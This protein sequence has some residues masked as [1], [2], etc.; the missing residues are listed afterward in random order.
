MIAPKNLKEHAAAYVNTAWPIMMIFFIIAAYFNASWSAILIGYAGWPLFLAGFLGLLV[1]WINNQ[2][3]ASDSAAVS[4]TLAQENNYAQIKETWEYMKSNRLFRKNVS[5]WTLGWSSVFIAYFG[6]YISLN[7]LKGDI[8]F[9]NLSS[10]LFEV[11]STFAS[12]VI[13]QRFPLKQVI[14]STYFIIGLSFSSC[15]LMGSKSQSDDDTAT[16]SLA[17]FISLL[18][19]IIAKISYEMMWTVLIQ[20]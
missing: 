16:L 15:L 19:V 9:N 18:P 13:V 10:S 17:V 12:I 4:T 2:Q 1:N 6:C 20:Y 5:L 11:F 3:G 7:K 8:Y 14:T